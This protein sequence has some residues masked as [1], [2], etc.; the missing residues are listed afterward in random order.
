MA[1]VTRSSE[2]LK[3][4]GIVGFTTSLALASEVFRASCQVVRGSVKVSIRPDRTAEF[5]VQR[6]Q[7]FY[8]TGAPDMRD[9]RASPAPT[10]QVIPLIA[11]NYEGHGGA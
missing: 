6:G 2:L 9:F 10:S 5:D 3:V 7:T 1:S 4:D 11:V 8:V